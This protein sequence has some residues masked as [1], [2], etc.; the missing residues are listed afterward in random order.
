M[1]AIDA[2]PGGVTDLEVNRLSLP[3]RTSGHY[4]DMDRHKDGTPR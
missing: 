1:R 4:P 3:A 2:E